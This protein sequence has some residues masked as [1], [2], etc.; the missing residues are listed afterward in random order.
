MN[1]IVRAA[2]DGRIVG[3]MQATVSRWPRRSH[4]AGGLD[5]RLRPPTTRLRLRGRDRPGRDGSRHRAWFASR[6]TST[7]ITMA[8]AGVARNA[9]LMPT[10]ETVDGEVVWRLRT[11]LAHD[12]G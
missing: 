1:W 3:T 8:S 12:A 6:R 9:G 10:D 2:D 4:G 7:R 11:Q 5:G